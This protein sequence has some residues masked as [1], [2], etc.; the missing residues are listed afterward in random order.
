MKRPSLI[1][2]ALALSRSWLAP[3]E[4]IREPEAES[5]HRPEGQ[6]PN[7]RGKDSPAPSQS[8]DSGT[9]QDMDD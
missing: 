6:N 8:D 9:E 7:T 1:D 4:Y 3:T 5:V 2:A